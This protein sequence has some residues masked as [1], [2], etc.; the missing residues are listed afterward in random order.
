MENELINQEENYIKGELIY[1]IFSNQA[2]QFSIAKIKVIETTEDFSDAE[3]IIKG[4]FGEL[5]PSEVYV[6]KGD[7]VDHKKFGLQYQV[8]HYQR[9][10]PDS[11]EGLIVYLSSDLFHGVGIKTAERIVDQLGETAVSK[12]LN[13]PKVLNGIQGL[14]KERKA[15]F[16]QKLTEHQGFDHV[17]VNLAKFGIGLKMAQKI[18]QA[19]KDQ[20][21]EV[22]QSNPYQYVFDIEGFGFQRADE[23]A[24]NN[25][26]PMDYPARLQAGCLFSMQESIN[27]GHVYLPI[28]SLIEQANLLLQAARY[29]I[30]SE[31]IKK[32]LAE[33]HKYRKIVIDEERVYLTQLY[34]AENGFCT[35]LKRIIKQPF[36]DEVVDAEL[37][38]I[39]GSIEEEEVLSYGKEQFRAIEQALS[40]KVMIL[41]GGPGTGKTTVIK[42]IIRAY[43]ELYDL[44][45]DIADYDSKAKFP[46]ILTAPTGRAAKRITEST[47]LPALTIHRLLGWDGN[48]NYE[49][50][51]HNQLA[52]RLLV[53]DEFSMVDIFLA[54]RLFKAIPNDMQVLIVGDQDQLPSVGPG[55]VLADLLLSEQVSAIELDEVYRQK[56]G[57]QIIHLAHQ[58]KQNKVNAES[59][60]KADDFN[61]IRSSEGH[62]VE[63]VKQIVTK[64]ESKGVDIK[65]MQVLAPMYRTNV[66]IHR[67]NQEIQQI[68]NP[69]RKDV[70]EIRTKDTVFRMGDKVIQLVN[71]AEDGVFNGDIGQITAIFRENEN[72]DKEEQVVVSYDE[73]DVVYNRKE[74]LNIMHAYCISIHKSQGSEFPIVVLP[75][76]ANFRR[77]LRKNLLYTAVTRAKKSLIICGDQ[78]AFM[79][80]IREE[81]TN[82]RFTTL[83]MKLGLTL[84]DQEFADRIEAEEKE[85]DSLS[86]YDF[87]A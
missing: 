4:Y 87:L 58:I 19:Y 27:N 56:E 12:I 72:V 22:L 48:E 33:L 18:Y 16:V 8:N 51:E 10:L 66:G 59:L 83:S 23:I 43:S 76:A 37:L 11:K 82:R 34:Y 79:T 30:D 36:E 57:S 47:G 46:F 42:G 75:V 45:L 53:I 50:N 78:Q 24:I 29:K 2:E 61:F 25:E 63:L 26:L 17:V 15:N 28:L 80:G 65:D 9:Y 41:T 67:L 5:H 1:M 85:E 62:L 32:E 3:I 73:N 44:S 21:I 49:K 6:F 55:Q 52:G 77:M 7:F 54:N 68:V 13:D 20:A 14:N 71:Q 70:R 74:L 31:Q 81:D 38:K 64:A 40:N 84:E 69:K 35:Q 39:V 86:P 60:V